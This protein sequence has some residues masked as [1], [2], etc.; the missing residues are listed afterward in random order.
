[1]IM[2]KLG[3]VLA[4][5]AMV[6]FAGSAMA[7]KPAGKGNEAPSGHHFTLNLVGVEDGKTRNKGSGGSVIFVRL[8]T[9]TNAAET[10][11]ELCNTTD[12]APYTDD[13]QNDSCDEEWLTNGFVVIDGDGTLLGGSEALFGLPNPDPDGDLHSEYSLFIRGHGKM[14]TSAEI[15]VCGFDGDSIGEFCDMNESVTV[16]GGGGSGGKKFQN[17]TRELLFIDADG[18][19]AGTGRVGLFNDPYEDLWWEYDNKG[20]RVTQ[21]RFY[22]C[23]TEL[24][25][26]GNQVDTTCFAE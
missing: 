3:L 15:W 20:L 16:S 11:I 10:K 23:S 25:G 13:T 19:G 17:V 18:P 2:K 24:D 7:G 4:A 22:W 26:N 1:M 12:K 8:G 6:A 14:G 5:A 9:K 21:M